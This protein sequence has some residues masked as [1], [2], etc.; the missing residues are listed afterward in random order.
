MGNAFSSVYFVIRAEPIAV[1]TSSRGEALRIFSSPGNFLAMN[2]F[3]G[4]INFLRR[5]ERKTTTN[6]A[7]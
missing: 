6:N 3:I 1:G 7:G 5:L 4:L 2:F